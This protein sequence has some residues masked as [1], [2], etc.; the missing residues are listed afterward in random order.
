LGAALVCWGI[1]AATGN[2]LFAALRHIGALVNLFNLLPVWSLDGSRGMRGLSRPLGLALAVAAVATALFTGNIFA[3]LIAGLALI[4]L[5][6][7]RAQ[8][9][10][11]VR[12]DWLVF[13][14]FVGLIVSLA[15]IANIPGPADPTPPKS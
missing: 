4:R 12:P 15:W 3:W 7:A 2:A 5:F 10:E 13:A 9:P 6:A 1:F 8:E 11:V 14:L